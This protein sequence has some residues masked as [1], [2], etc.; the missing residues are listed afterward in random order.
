[1]VA[2]RDTHLKTVFNLQ[3]WTE[4]LPLALEERDTLH[5]VF[6]YCQHRLGETEQE[7]GGRGRRRAAMGG[8]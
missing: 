7:S 2:V 3:E 1:M 6:A 4:T 5:A 8:V